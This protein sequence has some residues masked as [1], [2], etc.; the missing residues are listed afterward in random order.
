MKTH[1]LRKRPAGGRILTFTPLF[2]AR[3]LAAHP[4]AASA[5]I[6]MFLKRLEGLGVQALLDFEQSERLAKAG[7]VGETWSRSAAHAQAWQWVLQG[8]QMVGLEPETA[9]AALDAAAQ[10]LI[11][12]KPKPRSALP[13]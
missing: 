2:E 7:L 12:P 3:L 1:T 6:G 9:L 4:Y 13:R 8:G 10:A 11:G 5:F